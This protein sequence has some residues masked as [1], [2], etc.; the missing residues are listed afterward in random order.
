MI[1]YIRDLETALEDAR[2]AIRDANDALQDA[3][4]Y[5]DE[6]VGWEDDAP[7]L[8][9]KAGIDR[10]TLEWDDAEGEAILDVLDELEGLAYDAR[11]KY[12]ELE[13][14]VEGI[15]SDLDDVDTNWTIQ[16]ILDQMEGILEKVNDFKSE[17]DEL[18]DKSY[19]ATRYGNDLEQYIAE[20]K[21]AQNKEC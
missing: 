6:I 5:R 14:T 1:D 12:D 21:K 3:G 10:N 11:L 19:E 17:V 8:L 2:D 15:E 9:R 4:S 18:L 13:N 7:Y 20:W 16:D